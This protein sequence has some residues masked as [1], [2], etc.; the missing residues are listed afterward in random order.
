MKFKKGDRVVKAR[1]WLAE[2]YC[3]H[4]GDEENC[5]I[6]TVGTVEYRDNNS[7]ICVQFDNGTNWELH[8]GELDLVKKDWR[9]RM[10]E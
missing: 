5:P 2:K 4:G 6:G 3:Y 9:E 7:C 1:R 8:N 10:G